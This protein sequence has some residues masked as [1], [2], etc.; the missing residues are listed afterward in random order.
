MEYLA[1]AGWKTK[2]IMS[3]MPGMLDLAAAGALDLGR[4]ADIT[5]DTMAAFKMKA[6]EAGHAAD[7]FAYAQANANTNVEQ[8]GEG[9]KYLAPVANNMGW[10]LE[11]TSAA[12]MALANQGLKGSI[13]GQAFA[14]S[15]GRL[16]KPTKAMQGV[17][18]ELNIS[19]F[20]AHGQMKSMPDIVREL[21]KGTKGLTDKQR[22]AAL[23]TLFGAEAYKHWSILLNTGSKDLKNM[24][25]ELE[26][27]DGT[28]KKMADTMMDNFAGAM[29]ELRSKLEE[30]GIV[31]S[32]KLTPAIRAIAEWVGRA[33][34]KFNKM[35]AGTQNLILAIAGIA[36][37][38]GPVVVGMGVFVK[39]LGT[40]TGGLSKT[41]GWFGRYRTNLATTD[42]SMKTFAATSTTAVAKIN[43]TNATMGRA[44][45]GMRGLRGSAMLAGAA[46]ATFGG[47]WGGV[48]G[49]ASVFLPGILK[50]GKGLLTFGNNALSS[51]GNL[52][53]FGGNAKTASKANV[54]LAGN[55]GK[56]SRG[57]AGLAGK[58]LGAVKGIAGF[59]GK[60]LGLVKNLGSLTKVLG[61]ARA[62]FSVLGGPVGLATTGITLLAEGGYKLYKQL[63]KESIPAV[64]DFGS[65][66]SESTTEAVLGYKK[67]NDDA[68]TQ[69]NE[70]NWS[71][72][73]VSKKTAE[74][75][76]KTFGEM[77]SQISGSLKSNFNESYGALKEFLS[78]SKGIS[79]KEQ[80]A[81][82][83]N[84]KKKHE[85]QQKTV[86]GYQA[87]IKEIMEKARKEKRQLTAN[88]RHEIND[89]QQKMA[90]TAVKTMSKNEKEQ[91]II[92]ERLKRSSGSITAKQ[93]ADTVKNSKKARDGAISDAKKKFK[94]VE[95]WAIYESTVTGSISK[96]EADKIIKEAR[97]QKDKSI[98]AAKDKHKKVV[99]HAKSQAGG[100]AKHVD[101]ATG[102][103]LT[104]WDKMIAGVAVAV[105]TVSDGIN[106]VLD[107]IGMGKY[108]IPHWKPKGY[109]KG[110]KPAARRNTEG[111]GGSIGYYATGT[112]SSGHP[113]GPAIVGERGRELAHIP[114]QGVTLVG[115]KGPELIWDLPRGSSVLPNR[116]TEK[117]LKSYGFPGYAGGVGDFFDWVFEGPRYLMNKVWGKFPIPSIDIG[118]MFSKMGAGIISF[119][120]NKSLKFI[121]D[122]VKGFMDSFGS[123]GDG[124]AKGNIGKWIAAAVSITG[125][126]KSWI[127]PLSTIAQKE[128]GG[129]PKAINLW[130]SNA[131]AGIP[132][133][134][135]MQTIDP[136]FQA[137]KKPGMNDIWN[138]VHN[139]VAAIRY[140]IARYGNVFNVPG[141]RSMARGGP[142][143]G[144]AS[145]G[146]INK[147]QLAMLGENGFREYAITTEPRYRKRSLELWSQLGGELGA[148]PEVKG[149]STSAA[150]V[151]DA[152][153]IIANEIAQAL[154]P[155][156]RASGITQNLNFYTSE[157]P[158]PSEVA[159]RTKQASRRL[160]ME[161]GV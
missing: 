28:A 136:T 104:G 75:L 92:L 140:I 135:L 42:K 100:Q 21:E 146:I 53:K 153:S 121:G 64:N 26:N 152:A 33:T 125:V 36:A 45:K 59:G 8:L 95:E 16:A 106:W 123:I 51:A 19:F 17:M 138:P 110:K 74:N 160:A 116:E 79:S 129:N 150:N 43:A 62:G 131:K 35:D 22:S 5:S 11:G 18:K 126:P 69:L 56:S 91:V 46:M 149:L 66:V 39:S 73:K 148:L 94:K 32:D 86:K 118:G 115:T 6:S 44:S 77:G 156:V 25:K 47:E 89:I 132:S 70:L 67:L 34:D 127:G 102:E 78:N 139:A 97:R 71:G 88:E 65:E 4:A 128:S 14:S 48:A 87:R 117:T 52:L 61:I 137:Y 122:K 50:G 23:T 10:S 76:T 15:L 108:K 155:I 38:L 85:E 114:G 143:M 134:G 20:D 124:S 55:V 84:V 49:I 3:A 12:M 157:S 99:E 40:I 147:P 98:K 72:Q 81:I 80:Q 103:V 68:T 145:G 60:A 30:A 105:N 1:L 13:A 161:L 41:I 63:T 83:D 82:L 141:I 9:M 96:K 109:S 159:R 27:S 142:Y 144:Y 57:F 58:A 54:D 111:P 113:G 37:A 119:L 107:L 112:P 7:V 29:K 101:W 158:P 151:K 31:I 93:A 130:D 133:K 24:T 154:A 120:K 90:D 2:D